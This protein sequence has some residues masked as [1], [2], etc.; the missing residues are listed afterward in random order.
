MVLVVLFGGPL[1]L[2]GQA[3]PGPHR[4]F[5]WVAPT[6]V[7]PAALPLDLPGVSTGIAT[8][9]SLVLPGSG[10]LL[11]GHQRWVLFAGIELT[12]W[13]IHLDQHRYGHQLRN[14]YFDLAWMVAR[15]GSPQPRR[16]GDW[17]YFERLGTWLRS[18]S[19]DSDA[20]KSGVQ[21]ESDPESFN[22]ATWALARDL[23]LTPGAVEGDP[24]Y[25][26]ALAF[27]R[28]RAYPVELAW[29]WTDKETS[30]VQYRALIKTSDEALR[31]ATVVLG[32]VVANHLLSAVDAF[33]SSHAPAPVSAS[34]GL[35]S[36]PGGTAVTWT[37]E[38]RP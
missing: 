32:A 16:E 37:V 31:T 4:E 18:G 6:R 24:S 34:A 5:A 9:A 35:R 33:V 23:F 7:S 2:V 25:D 19:Y 3:A 11:L 13:L 1:G 36:L 15:N 17:E 29:D 21:P 30:Q 27:Y 8:I 20:S 14:Q 22:G 12:G 10:Q 26:K 38:I 28:K